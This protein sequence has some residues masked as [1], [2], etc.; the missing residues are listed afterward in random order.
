MFFLLRNRDTF[1][2]Y[3]PEGIYTIGKIVSHMM[4]M[5]INSETHFVSVS[6]YD[7]NKQWRLIKHIDVVVRIGDSKKY[8]RSNGHEKQQLQG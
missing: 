8:A 1:Y 2:K 5:T 6:S 3:R 7:I 4:L